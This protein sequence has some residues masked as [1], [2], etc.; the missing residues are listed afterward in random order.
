MFSASLSLD[1]KTSRKSNRPA[2]WTVPSRCRW[3]SLP[4]HEV[5]RL[6][7]FLG[8]RACG[9]TKW[10]KP[11]L[12]GDSCSSRFRR[13]LGT[14]WSGLK[15]QPAN[16]PGSVETFGRGLYSA[17]LFRRSRHNGGVEFQNLWPSP[18]RPSCLSRRRTRESRNALR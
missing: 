3:C 11:S 18:T 17:T 7:L 2:K 16:Q 4:R 15:N 8:F 13:R 1:W 6:T 9:V 5:A 14:S 12:W 10:P